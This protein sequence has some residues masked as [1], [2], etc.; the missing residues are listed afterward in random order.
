ML[1]RR[2]SGLGLSGA[3]QKLIGEPG[4]RE[5]SD[6][7]TRYSALFSHYFNGETLMD[8]IA[9]RCLLNLSER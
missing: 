1:S 3:G 7:R 2:R 6:T 5:V 8:G 4:N 9:G